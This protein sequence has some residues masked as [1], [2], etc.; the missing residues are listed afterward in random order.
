MKI[1]VRVSGIV[2]VNRKITVV[3]HEN[4][5]HGTYYL[6]PGGGLE[7]DETIQECAIR[8]VKEEC[9][10]DVKI[11]SL[12]YYED[13]V[14]E[15]DHTLHLIFWCDLLGGKSEILDPD[16]KIKEILFFNKLEFANLSKFFPEPLKNQL[17]ED[18]G[19]LTPISLGKIPF[20]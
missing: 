6:L 2:I 11:K 17:F 19:S 3:R 18:M 12:A 1:N 13:V 4:K 10:F 7:R 15:D 14:S 16:K 20:P 9:G 5:M 8:E